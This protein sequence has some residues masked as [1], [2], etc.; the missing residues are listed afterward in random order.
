MS[1]LFIIL[2]VIRQGIA[3]G[4]ITTDFPDECAEDFYYL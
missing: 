2:C 4:S 1:I 3:D